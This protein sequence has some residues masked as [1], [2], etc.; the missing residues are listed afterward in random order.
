MKNSNV[1]FWRGANYIIKCDNNN[2]NFIIT[3]IFSIVECISLNIRS[4][5]NEGEI[6]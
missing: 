5:A 4:Y 3:V 1:Y 6:S 2:N